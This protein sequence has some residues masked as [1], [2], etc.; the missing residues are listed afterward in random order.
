MK[1]K[2]IEYLE[3]NQTTMDWYPFLTSAEYIAEQID[4][5]KTPTKKAL[6]ELRKDWKIYWAKWFPPCDT[7]YESWECYCENH[8]PIRWWSIKEIN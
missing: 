5:L 3:E 6:R 4:E 1:E 7:D 2:I 8:L